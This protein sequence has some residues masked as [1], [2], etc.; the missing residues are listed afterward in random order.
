M[1]LHP[2]FKVGDLARHCSMS[3]SGLYAFFREYAGT[4]PIDMKHRMKVEQ[5][6]GLL[7]TTDLSIEEISD[8]LKFS[9]AAYFRKIVKEQTGKT[10][11]ALRREYYLADRL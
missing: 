2:D 7:A 6:I 1:A 8:R 11:S 5:A 9:S 4:T 10:P 3:E